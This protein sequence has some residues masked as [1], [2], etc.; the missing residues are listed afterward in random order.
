MHAEMSAAGT[1]IR[2]FRGHDR[3]SQARAGVG[4][5]AR[6]GTVL[7]R[8]VDVAPGT[9][10]H[11]FRGHSAIIAL[12]PTTPRASQSRVTALHSGTETGDLLLQAELVTGARNMLHL[13]FA[14]AAA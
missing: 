6:S 7:F 13:E 10:G 4:E 11:D 2:L 5:A 3:P 1:G 8:E 14:W 9:E 12:G